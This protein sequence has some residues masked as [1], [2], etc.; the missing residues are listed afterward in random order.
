MPEPMEFVGSSLVDLTWQARAV[1]VCTG[2]NDFGRSPVGISATMQSD[3]KGKASR[4]PYTLSRRFH[5]TRIY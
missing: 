3:V 5:A 4:A 2:P 1:A